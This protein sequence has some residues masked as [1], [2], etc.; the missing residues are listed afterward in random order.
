MTTKQ[1]VPVTATAP[2]ASSTA[3][4]SIQGAYDLQVH[5]APDIIARRIDDLGL[6][7]EF[8]DRGLKG[9]VL[10]S[11]YLCT[12][13]RAK[14]V[15]ASVPGIAAYGAITLNH[16]VGGLNPVAVDIAGRSGAKV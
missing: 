16:S 4:D 1:T 8:L 9:F 5:V 11:H 14:V 3:W 10:K 2:S 7:R 6:A 15:C 12:A 13:E